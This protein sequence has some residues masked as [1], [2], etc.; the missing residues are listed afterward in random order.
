MEVRAQ[1]PITLLTWLQVKAAKD[2]TSFDMLLS[3]LFIMAMFM[4]D[5][6]MV[7]TAEG[8]GSSNK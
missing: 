6:P 8:C 4:L 5:I 1:M 2:N 7:V 3:G